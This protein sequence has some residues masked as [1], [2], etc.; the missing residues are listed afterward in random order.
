MHTHGLYATLSTVE[1]KY[2][3]VKFR[4][5]VFQKQKYCN[6]I[7][8]KGQSSSK[9]THLKCSAKKPAG[10]GLVVAS[11]CILVGRVG[12]LAAMRLEGNPPPQ[13]LANWPR[14]A[15][16]ISLSIHFFMYNMWIIPPFPQGEKELNAWHPQLLSKANPSFPFPPGHHAYD[17][18]NMTKVLGKDVLKY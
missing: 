13:F 5:L 8:L 2:I 4:I 12:T 11:F 18:K 16:A 14:K 10:Q 3:Y 7:F 6:T 17:Q 9:L 15:S 1:A